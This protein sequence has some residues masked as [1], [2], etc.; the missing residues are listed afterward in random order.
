MSQ[1]SNSV[2]PLS[3]DI[4]SNWAKLCSFRYSTLFCFLMRVFPKECKRNTVFLPKNRQQI[5]CCCCSLVNIDSIKKGWFFDSFVQKCGTLYSQLVIQA[6]AEISC[7]KWGDENF[8]KNNFGLLLE[9]KCPIVLKLVN[10]GL[11]A[12]FNILKLQS[13]DLHQFYY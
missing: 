1:V 5:I 7:W 4:Y 9:P 6:G 12:Y 8:P 11:L 3:L 2:F 13:S 10:V